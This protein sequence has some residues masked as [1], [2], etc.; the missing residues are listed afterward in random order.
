MIELLFKLWASSVIL[1]FVVCI[2]GGTAFE[3]DRYDWLFMWLWAYVVV[4]ASTFVVL[5]L[6]ALIWLT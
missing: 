5:F 3:N 2:I 1:A 4:S 6:F